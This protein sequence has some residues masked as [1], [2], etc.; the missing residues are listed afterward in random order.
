MPPLNV[1]DARQR[2]LEE[3]V[4]S[5][6]FKRA[7]ELTP[8]GP[9]KGYQHIANG[10][11]ESFID[12]TSRRVTI[13]SLIKRRERL[14]AEAAPPQERP[15]RSMPPPPKAKSKVVGDDSPFPVSGP[16]SKTGSA[17]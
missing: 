15:G 9:T 5:V 8:C 6:S 2:F 14:L 17:P 10:E 11:W 13:R 1:E 12:G 7:C 3:E 4:A 16:P